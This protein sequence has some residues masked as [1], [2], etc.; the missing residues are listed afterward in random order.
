MK[1]NA[2]IEKCPEKGYSVYIENEGIPFGIIGEGSTIEQAKDDFMK[3]LNL[4][5]E[6][7]GVEC[8]VSFYLDVA[9]ILAYYS[10][11][12][13]LKGLNNITGISEPVLKQYISG[14]KKPTRATCDRIKTSL[15]TFGSELASV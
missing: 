6:E 10:N 3:G 5:Q 7:Y 4:A 11:I 14:L 13:S 9:S 8:T 2:V 15:H 1:I 12:V